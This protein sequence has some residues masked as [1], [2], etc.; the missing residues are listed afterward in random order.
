MAY[1]SGDTRLIAAVESGD[2]HTQVAK[3]VWPEVGWAGDDGPEDRKVAEQK[4][5]RHFTYRDQAKRGAHGTNYGGM[6][7]T[8]A[9]HIGIPE[10][11]AVEFQERYFDAFPGVKA[12]H[13][14]VQAELQECGKLTT[15]LGRER[16]FFDR[17]DSRETLKEA[18]AWLPQ[19]LI[20]DI[21]KIG[22]LRIWRDFEI[23]T[24]VLKLHA[25]MHDGCLMSIRDIYLDRV[26]P[27][28][29]NHMTI[30][31]RFPAGVM[32][33]P[34]DFTVGYQWQ[35]KAMLDWEPGVLAKLTR[36]EEKSLLDIEASLI[37]KT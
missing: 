23:G 4:F 7:P 2:L 8:M 30:P 35:K 22:V 15:A 29:I 6:A 37:E 14:S 33:I 36:P 12:W 11:M 1:Y 17:L 26:A 25:D 34:V 24:P 18:L 13:E 32:T 27:R 3:L 31:V 28:I 20:S 16:I 9:K 21:L 5:Y 10:P 19:S